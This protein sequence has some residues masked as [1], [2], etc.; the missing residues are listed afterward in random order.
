MSSRPGTTV[1]APRST[2]PAHPDALRP[3][4][5]LN[6]QAWGLSFGLV[7]GLGL[8]AATW[9]LVIQGGPNLGQHLGLLS[10]F[11]PGYSVTWHGGLIGFVYAF[12]GGWAVGRLIGAVYNLQDPARR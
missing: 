8:L 1:N 6:A 12:V 4:A 5:R 10:V 3:L 2:P 7:A 9:I 11:L